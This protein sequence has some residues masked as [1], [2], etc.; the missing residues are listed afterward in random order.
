MHG[1]SGE[2]MQTD[3]FMNPTKNDPQAQGSVISYMRRYALAAVLGL[4]LDND[5]DANAA[6]HGIIETHAGTTTTAPEKPWLNQDSKV[7]EKIVDR[8]KN[9]TAS[10]EQISATF[11][12][13]QASPGITANCY[14]QCGLPGQLNRKTVGRRVYKKHNT[15]FSLTILKNIVFSWNSIT[16]AV[17]LI[18][19]PFLFMFGINNINSF[20]F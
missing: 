3:Y 1:E 9:K 17:S 5:D 20:I 12:V 4:N 18:G 13:K 11:Q 15:I 2:Y 19:L 7:Y 8:L 6:T 10:L 16:E 14:K